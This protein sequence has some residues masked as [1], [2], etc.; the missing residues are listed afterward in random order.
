[1]R[2]HRA[3]E[4]LLVEAGAHQVADRLDHSVL[5][6]QTRAAPRGKA[7]LLVQQ[8]VEQ[9]R[10]DLADLELVKQLVAQLFEEGRTLLG[11]SDNDGSFAAGQR[12]EDFGRG[13]LGSLVDDAEVV[14]DLFHAADAG[15]ADAC[16]GDDLGRREHRGVEIR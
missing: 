13:R 8:S 16:P 6:L 1:M 3:L 11:V 5:V 7:R 4:L 12:N 2:C 9:G 14:A 15:D 10:L